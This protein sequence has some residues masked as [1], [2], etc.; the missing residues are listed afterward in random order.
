MTLFAIKSLQKQN[1]WLLIFAFTIQNPEVDI[2]LDNARVKM[3][4]EWLRSDLLRKLNMCLTV[5]SL[6]HD[7]ILWNI[8]SLKQ[9]FPFQG[10]FMTIDHKALV[11][12][13][14]DPDSGRSDTLKS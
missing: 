5:Y 4:S 12:H 3:A 8:Y 9:N 14:S 11:W 6:I 2:Q 1:E 7:V 10:E 13:S